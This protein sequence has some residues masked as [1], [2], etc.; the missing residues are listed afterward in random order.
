MKQ[1]GPETESL[2]RKNKIHFKRAVDRKFEIGDK[3]YFMFFRV[4]MAGVAQMEAACLSETSE[5]I[6]LRSPFVFF[7]SKKVGKCQ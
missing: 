3:V 5:S 7:L 6:I 1:L 2:D 4:F